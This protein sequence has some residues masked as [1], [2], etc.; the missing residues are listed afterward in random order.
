MM[1]GLEVIAGAYKHRWG[2]YGRLVIAI[3]IWNGS[4]FDLC[5]NHMANKLHALK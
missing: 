4:Q 2:P 5:S 3:D 1:N